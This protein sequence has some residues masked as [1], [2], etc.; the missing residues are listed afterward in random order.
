[1]WQ[2]SALRS[3]GIRLA[4]D[5]FGTGHSSLSYLQR[6]PI[7]VVKIDRSFI[8]ELGTGRKPKSLVNSMITLSHELGYRVVGE[9]VETADVAELL[10]E[11]GCD[12]AQGYLFAKPMG[13]AE[14]ERW[15]S[16]PKGISHRIAS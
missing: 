16:T 4:I 9:G 7:D 13:P 11:L 6:L 3:T 10:R 5:D 14:F 2:L 15:L 8:K 12:E 1:M